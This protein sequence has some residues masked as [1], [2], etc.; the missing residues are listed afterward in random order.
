MMPTVTQQLKAMSASMER[1]VIP[2]LPAE[3]TFV[4]EQAG[5]ILA[6]LNW[7]LDVHESEYRYEVTEAQDYRG[8]LGAL[9]EVE[10]AEQSPQSA[11]I[12]EVLAESPA[13]SGPTAGDLGKV[14][15]QGRRMK[16]LA[17][18]FPASADEGGLEAHQTAR[19][20]VLAVAE[21]QATREQAWYRS[22]GFI[23]DNPG[24]IA[25][26]LVEEGSHR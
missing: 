23:L 9:L 5:V 22:T 10:G 6:T 15:E 17:A 8:L 16:E 20:L 12:R 21:R 18:A 2:A 13:E 7:L 19:R 3:S 11:P 24:D 1:T 14:R 4:R 26:V 25:T